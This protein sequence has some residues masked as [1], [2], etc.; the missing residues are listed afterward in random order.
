MKWIPASE[1]TTD[2]VLE[3]T[4]VNS[5]GV[6]DGLP[7]NRIGRSADGMVTVEVNFPGGGRRHRTFAHDDRVAVQDRPILTKC[8]HGYPQSAPCNQLVRYYAL[9]A[10]SPDT[11]GKEASASIAGFCTIDHAELE[12]RPSLDMAKRVYELVLDGI[13]YSAPA[14]VVW[15]A[16][17]ANYPNP[18]PV[19]GHRGDAK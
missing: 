2:H 15:R 13:G 8:D 16:L 17:I 4:S 18:V 7:I 19:Q 12:P 14:A 5:T 3:Y 10:E 1:L 6:F 11:W 9:S